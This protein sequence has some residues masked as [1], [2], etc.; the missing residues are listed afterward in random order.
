MDILGFGHGYENWS[1]RR[2]L[3]AYTFVFVVVF[4][5]WLV[6]RW[7]FGHLFYDWLPDYLIIPIT[8]AIFGGLIVIGY[9][10]KFRMYKRGETPPSPLDNLRRRKPD[11]RP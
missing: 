5:V 11:Q 10:Q 1:P 8:V 4:G 3:A 6:A 2:R 7:F 9:V